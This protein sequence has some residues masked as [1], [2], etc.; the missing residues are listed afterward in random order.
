[1]GAKGRQAT[2]NKTKLRIKTKRWNDAPQPDDGFRLLV[3]RYRPRGISKDE[4]QWD[5]WWPELGPSVELHAAAYGKD[6]R[7]KLDWA[8]YERRYI[9]EMRGQTRLIQWLARAHAGGDPLT[10]LCSSACTDE[11][12][13]HRTILRH[14]IERAAEAKGSAKGTKAK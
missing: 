3:A 12:R 11:A 4:E 14:L 9:A 8:D 7:P 2:Y 10:L 5:A 1:M 13:C 6:G